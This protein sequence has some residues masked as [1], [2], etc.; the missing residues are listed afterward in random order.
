MHVKLPELTILKIGLAVFVCLLIS[1]ARGADPDQN[2]FY[3][4]IAAIITLK[5]NIRDSFTAGWT[6]IKA[7]IIGAVLGLVALEMQS[8]A[9]W[10]IDSLAYMLLLTAM[11]MLA[12]W[13]A[14]NVLRV[15]GVSLAGVALLSVALNH[16]SDVSPFSFATHR[17]VDTSLGIVV[18]LAVNAALPRT[19]K[20]F[21]HFLKLGQR[22]MKKED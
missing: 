22:K 3:A 16:A 2:T 12:L 7:T 8:A 21:G 4:C 20:D 11:V 6:R 19:W 13:F 10:Q 17:V 18:A 9:H 15:E 1:L 14:S 5:A